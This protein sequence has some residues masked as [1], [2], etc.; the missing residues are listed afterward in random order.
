[1]NRHEY[2]CRKN[3]RDSPDAGIIFGMGKWEN[4]VY[5]LNYVAQN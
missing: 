2:S 5:M 3:N 4:K 1:M